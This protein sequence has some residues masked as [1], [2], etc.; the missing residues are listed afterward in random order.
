MSSQG[1]KGK[2][3]HP[4]GWAIASCLYVVEVERKTLQTSW[5]LPPPTHLPDAVLTAIPHFLRGMLLW[6]QM[7]AH[8]QA[9]KEG[10]VW[11][12]TSNEESGALPS[13]PGSLMLSREFI[14]ALSLP[15]FFLLKGMDPCFSS[16]H[17][18]T[19]GF[20]GLLVS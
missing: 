18:Y 2:P 11:N 20:F 3:G 8:Q 6:S 13:Q 16:S 17:D 9:R 10:F 5:A 7:Q 12:R 1:G 4:Q 14:W 15:T 19:L